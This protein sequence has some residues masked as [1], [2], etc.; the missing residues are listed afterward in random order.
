MEV[1]TND[2]E[3]LPKDAKFCVTHYVPLVERKHP[4]GQCRETYTLVGNDPVWH[5]VH[6]EGATAYS[7]EGAA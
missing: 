3:E 2:D 4:K 5:C 7:K 1:R 6:D